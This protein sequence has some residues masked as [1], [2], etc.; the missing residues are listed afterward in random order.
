MTKNNTLAN[1]VAGNNNFAHG[2][3]ND[4]S[5]SMGIEQIKQ[6]FKSGQQIKFG[7]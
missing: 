5:S 4:L 6:T 3:S 1:G 7:G 2:Y